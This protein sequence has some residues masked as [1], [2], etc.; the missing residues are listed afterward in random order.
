VGRPGSEPWRSGPA[1]PGDAAGV[2]QHSRLVVVHAAEPV[3]G[4]LDALDAQVEAPGGRSAPRCRDGREA[5]GRI[6]DPGGVVEAAG[7]SGAV[8]N[9]TRTGARSPGFIGTY[10]HPAQ[11]LRDA[12]TGR[13]TSCSSPSEPPTLP[14]STE[15]RDPPSRSPVA[16][17]NSSESIRVSANANA[18]VHQRP[19]HDFG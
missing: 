15:P 8:E 14:E 19:L 9:K 3:T 1:G 7:E 5:L 6:R 16:S 12:A 17:L 13:Q 10:N 11:Q 18:K 4:A 2:E